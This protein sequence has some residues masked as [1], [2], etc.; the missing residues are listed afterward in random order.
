M[1]SGPNALPTTSPPSN[2]GG[3]FDEGIPTYVKGYLRGIGQSESSFDINQAYSEAF[4][5]TDPHARG[6]NKNVARLGQR[7]A[8][9][10]YYQ[11]NRSDADY[12]E[13][14]LGMSHSQA[15]H[16]YGKGPS[17]KGTSSVEQQTAAVNEYIFRRYPQAYQNLAKT[18]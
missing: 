3:A 17:G 10:G 11:M 15:E 5:T 18:G 9:Y 16:L 14:N 4:N 1:P 7:G 6:F 8:D 13:A 2:P 12:A